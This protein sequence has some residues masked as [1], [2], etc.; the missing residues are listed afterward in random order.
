MNPSREI[1]ELSAWTVLAVGVAGTVVVA[2]GM[3]GEGGRLVASLMTVFVV[4]D[5][6]S[7][8]SRYC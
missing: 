7:R 6:F 3:G 2:A 4:T 8:A 1:V 5:V